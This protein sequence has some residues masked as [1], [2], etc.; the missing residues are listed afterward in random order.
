MTARARRAVGVAAAVAIGLAAAGLGAQTPEEIAAEPIVRLQPG[1]TPAPGQCLTQQQL[2]LI[3][4]LNALRRPT[5][6]V[7]A[8]GE[9]DDPAP[10]DPHYLVGEWTIEGVLPDSPL[11]PAGEFVGT[12]VVR[13]VDGCTYSSTLE[14]T[15]AEE[16]VTIESLMIY[17]RRARYLV[18][19]EDDSRGFRFVKVG[20]VGGDP[21]GY[22]SHHWE[23]PAVARPGGEVR[24]AGRTYMTSPFAYQVRMRISVD[25]G[26]FTNFGSV[27]WERAGDEP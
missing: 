15:I 2:D 12:E 3:D 8:N 20:R 26:P 7:E 17:D 19:V 14:A 27:W 4:A 22:F 25:G 10:F 6:G 9:G 16:A 5:V 18:R 1:E 24:L 13:H 11:A 21:G 23:A